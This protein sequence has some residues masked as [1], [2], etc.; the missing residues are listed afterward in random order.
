MPVAEASTPTASVIVPPDGPPSLDPVAGLESLEA[1]GGLLK[2]SDFF[3]ASIL[4]VLEP[5]LRLLGYGRFSLRAHPF[6]GFVACLVR[7]GTEARRPRLCRRHVSLTVDIQVVPLSKFIDMSRFYAL[8]MPL[9]PLMAS[10]AATGNDSAGR[11]SWKLARK[12]R[13]VFQESFVGSAADADIAS[14]FTDQE[15]APQAQAFIDNLLFVVRAFLSKALRVCVRVTFTDDVHARVRSPSP[16]G[17][18]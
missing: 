18:A 17:V 8:M 3:P 11:L 4:E 12:L 15:K 7:V 9:V 13:T 2:S 5:F 1:S 10:A 14:Y 6:C 16:A